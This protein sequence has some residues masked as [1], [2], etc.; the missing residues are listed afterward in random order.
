MWI[1]WTEQWIYYILYSQRRIFPCPSQSRSTC[2]AGAAVPPGQ[3]VCCRCGSPEHNNGFIIYCTARGESFFVPTKAGAHARQAQLF[4]HIYS[5]RR[6]FPCHSQS[7]STCQAGAAVPPGQH[8]C[9]RCGSP[10]QNNG[11]IIYSLRRIFPCPSQSR[12]TCQAGAA[13]PPGQHVCCRC[14]SPEQNNGFIIYSKRRIFPYPSLSRST[15]QASAAVPPGQYVYNHL[16]RTMDLLNTA[17]EES[18]FVPTKAGAHARQAQL[19]HQ[20]SMSLVQQE[21]KKNIWN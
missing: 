14:G 1:T 13:V 7:R 4:H 3:H 12:S 17:W 15:C 11:F 21:T 9:C 6:I 10:E 16:N 19:F 20:V 8:V 18:F 5:Q 2:Q